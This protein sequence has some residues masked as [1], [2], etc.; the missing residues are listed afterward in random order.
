MKGKRGYPYWGY[1]PT[2]RCNLMINFD[3]EGKPGYG[4]G[5]EGWTQIAGVG[6][7]ADNR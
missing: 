6:G 4:L 7:M 1:P 5:A 2:G 3:E